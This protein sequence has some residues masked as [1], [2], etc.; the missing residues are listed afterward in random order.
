MFNTYMIHKKV[1][2]GEKYKLKFKYFKNAKPNNIKKV[3]I[4]LILPF[5]P[6]ILPAT[7]PNEMTAINSRIKT[8]VIEHL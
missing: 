3:Y 4:K 6:S 1:R 2:E 8:H 5:S 7:K